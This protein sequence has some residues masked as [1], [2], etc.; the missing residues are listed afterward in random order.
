MAFQ[1]KVFVYE[2][3]S[4]RILSW[5]FVFQT[6]LGDFLIKLKDGDTRDRGALALRI[7]FNGYYSNNGIRISSTIT[8]YICPS[9]TFY[10]KENIKEVYN[11]YI[12]FA[13]S[14]NCIYWARPC[15]VITDEWWRAVS[16]WQYTYTPNIDVH[17]FF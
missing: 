2:E 16:L 5:V 14:V 12:S 4:K 13:F 7:D 17:F 11:I 10:V 8:Y 15:V 3:M 6:E 1:T 9:S